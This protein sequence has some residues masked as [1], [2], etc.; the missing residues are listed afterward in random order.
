MGWQ[1]LASSKAGMS[2]SGPRLV[3]VC[4]RLGQEADGG[5]GCGDGPRL[6]PFRLG[7]RSGGRIVAE[8]AIYARSTMAQTGVSGPVVVDEES[9]LDARS[10]RLCWPQG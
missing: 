8:L 5:E 3:R 2:V 1:A 7:R 9:F 10:S 4:V 6:A